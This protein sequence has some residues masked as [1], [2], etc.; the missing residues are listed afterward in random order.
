MILEA[1]LS[2][3]DS[4]VDAIMHA[5]RWRE[6]SVIDTQLQRSKDIDSDGLVR[7]FQAALLVGTYDENAEKVVKTLIDCTHANAE[8]SPTRLAS[9]LA[10]SLLSSLAVCS[11][12]LPR[13][14]RPW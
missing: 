6:P 3:C 12:L 5:V 1:I 9:S 14:L 10:S 4:V 8:P 7:A 11:P 13:R 2:D